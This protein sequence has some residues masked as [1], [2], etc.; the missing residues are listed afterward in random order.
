MCIRDSKTL[1]RFSRQSVD[2]LGWRR[3]ASGVLLQQD[4][5]TQLWRVIEP[6]NMALDIR[7]VFFTVNTLAE[8]RSD[9]VVE[10]ISLAEAGLVQ[11]GAEERVVVRFVDGTATSLEIGRPFTNE[12]GRTFFY[13]RRGGDVQV[14]AVREDVIKRLR[15]GFG[16]G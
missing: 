4:L 5:A 14:H 13:V 9:R 6:E 2:T 1:F 10:G 8:L 7:N 15:A 3:G 11:E 16:Q 12:R